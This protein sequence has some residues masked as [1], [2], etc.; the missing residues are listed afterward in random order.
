MASCSGA[1]LGGCPAPV[2]PRKASTPS[3]LTTANQANNHS[4]VRMPVKAGNQKFRLGLIKIWP[5]LFPAHEIRCLI[6]VPRSLGFIKNR[7][8]FN[9]WLCRIDKTVIA[10]MV[11]ILDKAL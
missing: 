7:Y 3:V 5:A 1:N 6:K 2:C 11:D 10:K 4:P 9:R 8:M